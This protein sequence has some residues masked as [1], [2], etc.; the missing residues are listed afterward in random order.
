MKR[1]RADKGFVTEEGTSSEDIHVRDG[2]AWSV[3]DFFEFICAMCK[4]EMKRSPMHESDV[5][6][7]VVLH[8]NMHLD[9]SLRAHNIVVPG[10][11]VRIVNMT[12]RNGLS[13]HPLW[14]MVHVLGTMHMDTTMRMLSKTGGKDAVTA[15]SKIADDLDC[16]PVILFVTGRGFLAVNPYTGCPTRPVLDERTL[17][18]VANNHSSIF[19][20]K[21]DVHMAAVEPLSGFFMNLW[22][23]MA[24]VAN[25]VALSQQ[26]KKSIALHPIPEFMKHIDKFAQNLKVIQRRPAHLDEDGASKRLSATTP[27]V[28]FSCSNPRCRNI[29]QGKFSVDR[30]RGSVTCQKCAVFVV[31]HLIHDGSWVRIFEGDGPEGEKKKQTGAAKNPLFSDMYNMS[32]KIAA[33]DAKNGGAFGRVQNR[34]DAH[35]RHD[36]SEMAF[37]T[38]RTSYKDMMKE[39]VFKEIQFIVRSLSWMGILGETHSDE[40]KALFAR[41]RNDR[42]HLHNI[43][44]NIVACIYLTCL[45]VLRREWKPTMRFTHTCGGCKK[46]FSTLKDKRTHDESLTCP[47]IDNITRRLKRKKQQEAKSRATAIRRV[48]TRDNFMTLPE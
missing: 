28:S 5:P 34:V 15:E 4:A 12:T 39:T 8:R 45:R 19:L 48:L 43:E 32:T 6:V 23:I 40:T 38:T 2:C 14:S 30:A 7:M 21:L 33:E 41:L 3:T 22:W 31:E 47:G 18:F 46:V 25:A 11:K 24:S 27:E 42:Q 36:A 16:A 10:I 17:R 1:A 37:R 26:S 29:D 20:R 44:E 9:P 13:I 35:H